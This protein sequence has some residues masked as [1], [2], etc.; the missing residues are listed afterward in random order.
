[1]M[2][3]KI[4]AVIVGI[5]ILSASI[6]TLF[7]FYRADTIGQQEIE[8]SFV[9]FAAAK[10]SSTSLSGVTSQWTYYDYEGLNTRTE[11]WS[12]WRANEPI[13]NFARCSVDS[14]SFVIDPD[15]SDTSG[16][17]DYSYKIMSQYSSDS[18]GLETP[19]FVNHLVELPFYD[20]V[21]QKTR[22]IRFYKTYI[23]LQMTLRVSGQFK[24]YQFQDIRGNS[25]P[26]V[27]TAEFQG[28]YQ[29]NY[30][31]AARDVSFGSMSTTIRI[32]VRIDVR[33]WKYGDYI[34]IDKNAW[35]GLGNAVIWSKITSVDMS[36]VDQ[37][38]GW[39]YPLQFSPDDFDVRDLVLYSNIDDALK[40]TASL[41][42]KEV[43]YIELGDTLYSTVYFTL[44]HSVWLG[45]N[46]ELL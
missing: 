28:N 42:S 22:I 37:T 26:Y 4:L 27:M 31:I 10:P 5:I 8:H 15:Y 43:E 35:N 45:T 12:T 34:H 29:Q 19:G 6:I 17:P 18:K 32:V 41:P 39:D 11:D 16:T 24:I 20:P 9:G 13:S 33:N 25:V 36:E 21:T 3:R 7:S 40:K 44:D 30:G 23:T 2:K 38:A 14:K 1:M 46:M